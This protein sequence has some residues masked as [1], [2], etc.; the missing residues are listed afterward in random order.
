MLS[1]S[2]PCT[3]WKLMQ[4][5]VPSDVRQVV[6]IS[7][8]H[9]LFAKVFQENIINVNKSE[10]F[11]KKTFT[12]FCRLMQLDRITVNKYLCH[13]LSLK[14]FVLLRVKLCVYQKHHFV[15]VS[16][17]VSSSCN[18]NTWRLDTQFHLGNSNSAWNAA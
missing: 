13:S 18:R 14:R 7:E 6:K 15:R 12:E 2:K 9:L 3:A 8:N 1:H 17:V 11:K 5:Y 16:H 4:K 10:N